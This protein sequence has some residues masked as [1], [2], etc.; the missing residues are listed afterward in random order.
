M[1]IQVIAPQV[2]IED[3]YRLYPEEWVLLEVTRPHKDYRRRTGH[4]LA[5][6]ENRDDLDEP[7]RLFRAQHPN[8]VTF[9]FF[10]GEVVPEGFVV[11]L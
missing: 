1:N 2:T 11:V 9:E 5:H 3:A 10:A 7:Y 8:A 4:V 6:S